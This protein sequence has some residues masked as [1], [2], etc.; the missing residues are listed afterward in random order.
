MFRGEVVIWDLAIEL[1]QRFD[2]R[3]KFAWLKKGGKIFSLNIPQD[4]VFFLRSF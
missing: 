4:Q 2:V 1:S 3:I